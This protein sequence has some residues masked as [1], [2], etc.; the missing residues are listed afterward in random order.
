MAPTGEGFLTSKA[1]MKNNKDATA[2]MAW[3]DSLDL[4]RNAK[5]FCDVASKKT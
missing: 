3:T 5:E 1:T 2:S 4:R